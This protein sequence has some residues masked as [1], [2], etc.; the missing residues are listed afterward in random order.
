MVPHPQLH[1][2]YRHRVAPPRARRHE[3]RQAGRVLHPVHHGPEK[4]GCYAARLLCE[5][6]V[7][8]GIL[9]EAIKIVQG[10]SGVVRAVA[11]HPLMLNALVFERH[12][13]VPYG[14][15]RQLARLVQ[16]LGM[17]IELRM[18]CACYRRMRRCLGQTGSRRTCTSWT[19]R[20]S[21]VSLK[22]VQLV[23]AQ[24]IEFSQTLET[25]RKCRPTL[26]Q[27][28]PRASSFAPSL[29]A[30]QDLQLENPSGHIQTSLQVHDNILSTSPEHKKTRRKFLASS[31]LMQCPSDLPTSN[32][33]AVFRHLGSL[34]IEASN[35][36]ERSALRLS[37][38][39]ISPLRR[40]DRADSQHYLLPAKLQKAIFVACSSWPPKNRTPA[41]AAITLL[42]GI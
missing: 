6:F 37:V 32:T 8:W 25:N 39:T 11:E 31:N 13:K 14:I 26:S 33:L 27:K 12:A 2:R 4:N 20:F 24:R 19:G 9:Q 7:R 17:P 30:S 36:S 16:E 29:W 42:D 5:D 21:Y 15:A 10:V 40:R 18:P 3:G 28:F 34:R 41:C 23:H 1:S 38:I 22:T 35:P